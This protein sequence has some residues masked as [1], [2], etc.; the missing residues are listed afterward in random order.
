MI[1]VFGVGEWFFDIGCFFFRL[2]G[3]VY[4]GYGFIMYF[5]GIFM[6]IR[7]R[8]F[9]DFMGNFKGFKDFEVLKDVE[10]FVFVFLL[11]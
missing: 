4:F 5:V 9:K 1:G 7:W 3:Y 8:N 2:G 6:V 11:G 10:G